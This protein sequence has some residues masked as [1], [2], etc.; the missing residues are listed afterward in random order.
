MS[1]TRV[2]VCSKPW[3][4]ITA[5][6]R[7]SPMR[8]GRFAVHKVAALFVRRDSVYK[9]MPGV[10]AFDFDRDALTFAG[11]MPVVAHPPCRSWGRLR[12]FVTPAPGEREL[13]IFAVDQVRRFGGV[14]EHP[15]SSTLWAVAGLPQ[16]GSFD[17][18]GGWT[19][20]ILQS[21][22]GHRADKAT[23]LYVVGVAP[24]DV[25]AIPYRLGLA[26]HVIAQCRTRADGTRKRKGDFD[27]RPEVSKAEREHTPAALAA[28]LVELARVSFVDACRRAA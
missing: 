4:P 14:L 1:A 7:W 24:C 15:A 8:N 21:A 28:W 2:C 6:L 19:L 22:W 13:A 10:D 11:G 20:P 25:P 27:W 17:Q 18:F 12:A 9:T 3:I 26:T 5:L 23:W 16:P